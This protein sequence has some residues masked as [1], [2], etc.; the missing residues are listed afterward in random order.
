MRV[1]VEA[2]DR[3]ALG[4]FITS[5][6]SSR[7]STRVAAREAWLEDNPDFAKQWVRS[8]WPML[9]QRLQALFMTRTRDEWAASFEGRDACVAPVL[10]AKE[11]ARRP[12]IMARGNYFER[13]GMLQAAP[14][15]R[16]NGEVKTPRPIPHRGQHTEEMLSWLRNADAGQVWTRPA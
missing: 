6:R 2:A 10:S 3:C 7:S 16:F 1:P 5:W 14:A 11:A 4:G 13:D 12:Q 15:P 8:R 9:K